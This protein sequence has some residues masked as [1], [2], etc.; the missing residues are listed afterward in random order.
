MSISIC[1][2]TYNR[3]SPL[4]R[5]LE[6]IFDG[7]ND[8][9]YEVIVADGGSTDGTVEY[10]KALDN[11]TLIEMG[12][13]T[14][15][16]KAYNACF[17]IAKLEYILWP[18]DDFTLAPRVLVDA[19]NLMDKYPEIAL[20]APKMKEPSYGNL[21]GVELPRN[22]LV[23]S[24]TSIFRASVLREINYFDENMRTSGADDDSCLSALK[25]GYTMIF[26]REVGVTHNR[27][28]D[29][30]SRLN[31]KLEKNTQQAE[32][33]QHKWA[34]LNSSIRK[35]VNSS[36]VRKLQ[37]YKSLFFTILCSIMSDLK[38]T[39]PLVKIGYLPASKLY[40]FSLEQC[41]VFKAKEYS[42]LKD[43]YLAQ[44]LPKDILSAI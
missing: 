33:F 32:Y 18:G 24:K 15:S 27:D 9:P 1:I 26:T 42:H 19:C 17:K 25:L 43:F 37:K 5:L 11:V 44:R 6:S 13:L 36:M 38:F 2:P 35:Y 7:F 23:L 40:D 21:P 34:D 39:R 29:E 8:Y 28:E 10:L 3:L 20:V 12:K 30:L 16:I 31:Q 41:I 4:K 22:C 14:G